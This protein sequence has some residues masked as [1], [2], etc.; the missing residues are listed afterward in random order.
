MFQ[1]TTTNVINSNQDLTTG[2]ALWSVQEATATKPASLHIKRVN[3]FKANNITAIYKA[4][5]VD[6][7]FAKATIDLAEV[8]GAKGES[9]QLAIYIGLTQASQDSRYANDLILKGKP[10]T[11]DFVWGD[12]AAAT[13]EKLI[14]TINKYELLVYGDK[15]LD[16]SY[17]GSFITIEAKN[18]YQIFRKLEISKF[19]ATAYHYRG[20]YNVVR[21]LEDLAPAAS[22]AAVTAT[23][24]GFFP[25]KEGF[26]TYSFL[27]HNLRIP[28]SSRTRAFAPNQDETPIV[29]AKYNQYTIYYCVNRGILGDNAVGDL[30]KSRTTHVFYVKQDLA[31]DFETA[32]AKVG[33]VTEVV[34]G[35]PTPDPDTVQGDVDALITRV[36]AVE[37]SLASKADKT[38][39]DDKADKTALDTT[40]NTVKAN[41]TA[42]DTAIA[43]KADKTA[44]DAKADKSYTDTELGKKANTADVYTKAQAD[45]KFAAKP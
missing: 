33:T 17:S 10:F 13:A 43:A 1:F 4:V 6:P 19:D 34:P 5:A 22:N 32:L 44:V 26:G 42:A 27:L 3:N 7:E 23:A 28:T 12:D 21:S 45:A 40:N 37:A 2:K 11:I 36:T 30:V 29:G 31:A 9:Y 24:E 8:N 38:A 20:E 25:G 16:V 35:T 41:K 18:E 39:L 15:L 14:K